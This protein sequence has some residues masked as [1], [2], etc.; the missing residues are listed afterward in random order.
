MIVHENAFTITTLEWDGSLLTCSLKSKENNEIIQSD[1]LSL[2]TMDWMMN[3]YGGIQFGNYG[4]ELWWVPQLQH[5]YLFTVLDM[6]PD[7]EAYLKL[8]KFNLA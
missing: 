2:K 4:D 6:M 8:K 1:S 5:F 7:W 3:E